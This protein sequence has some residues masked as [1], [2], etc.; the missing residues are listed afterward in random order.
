MTD[1][2]TF[3]SVT[4]C[5]DKSNA[6]PTTID[7]LGKW[8]QRITKHLSG[9]PP[10]HSSSSVLGL[11]TLWTN[12]TIRMELIPDIVMSYDSEMCAMKRDL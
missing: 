12:S 9:V 5:V 3:P 1:R 7:H 11:M 4:M 10:S 2:I 6:K 8:G